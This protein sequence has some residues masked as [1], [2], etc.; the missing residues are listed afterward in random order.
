M[1]KQ[2]T[3][4]L[5][6]C[7][8]S[9]TGCYEG[10]VNPNYN[11]VQADPIPVK[12]VG[13][14]SFYPEAGK[15]GSTVVIFGENFG[16]TKAENNVAFGGQFAEIIDIQSAIVVVRVPMNLKEGSYMV[17]VSANG[18]TAESGSTFEVMTEN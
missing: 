12:K 15:G 3:L 10:T 9:M 11:G 1:K 18:G 4:A 7:V 8:L 17:S 14:S 16:A 13:I 5:S 2:L 6:L